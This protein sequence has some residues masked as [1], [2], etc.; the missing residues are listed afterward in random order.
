MRIRRRAALAARA[1][2]A[3]PGTATPNPAC[4]RAGRASRR[5][6]TRAAS[7]S[8]TCSTRCSRPTTR[9]CSAAPR[10]HLSAMTGPGRARAAPSRWWCTSTSSSCR[11]TEVPTYLNCM[12]CLTDFEEVMGATR[13][14]PRSHLG[15][16]SAA[17]LQRRARCL[18]PRADRHGGGRSAGRLGDLLR[19]PHLAPVGHL[20]VRQDPLLADHA[21]AAAL[22]QADGQHPAQPAATR[23]TRSLSEDELQLLGFKAEPSGRIEARRP[24]GH[25]NTN[26]KTPYVPELRRGSERASGG[27][28]RH[29]RPQE[30]R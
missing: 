5:S 16:L 15:R 19:E 29:G 14:V 17:G 6:T 22:G 9:M 12:L 21:V 8:T 20:H 11:Y 13:V 24:D 26:R 3:R 28:G 10:A 4:C 27:A 7:S 30:R 18:Q 1:A 25:Q 2:A 23:C